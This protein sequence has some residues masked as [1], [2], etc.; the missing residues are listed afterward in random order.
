MSNLFNKENFKKLMDSI[1]AWGPEWVDMQNEGA[2]ED[3]HTALTH[4]DPE[5]LRM[6][7]TNCWMRADLMDC[8]KLI[9][10]YKKENTTNKVANKVREDLKLEET[11]K[12]F[13]KLT[14]ESIIQFK[15]KKEIN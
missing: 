11:K 14:T 15:N 8:L 12:S 1:E 9:E 5:L 4:S 2:Q 3:W 13:Q 10:D 6:F 7:G